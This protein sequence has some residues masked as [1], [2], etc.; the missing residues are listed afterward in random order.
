M[1]KHSS[2]NN[3]KRVGT[4]VKLKVPVNKYT[5]G[6]KRL[7]WDPKKTAL[8]NV[9]ARGLSWKI[10]DDASMFRQR[11]LRLN[12][13]DP[14]DFLELV[15]NKAPALAGG[16]LEARNTNRH[17]YYMKEEEVEYLQVRRRG[18]IF[19]KGRR[20]TYS[21]TLSVVSS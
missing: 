14:K 20:C 9:K 10:N 18:S 5:L 6:A 17:P 11:G 3:R 15:D 21:L 13:P 8:Q 7:G 2:K 19:F 16:S 12:A 1:V 4:R